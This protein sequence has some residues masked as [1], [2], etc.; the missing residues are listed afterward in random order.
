MRLG[1]LG[2]AN[3]QRYENLE[4]ADVPFFFGMAFRMIEDIDLV[5]YSLARAT[6]KETIDAETLGHALDLIQSG[7][8]SV[9]P[10]EGAI[11][12]DEAPVQAFV[13]P[14]MVRDAARAPLAHDDQALGVLAK[15]VNFQLNNMLIVAARLAQ[16]DDLEKIQLRHYLP[17]CEELPYPLNRYC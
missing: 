2:Y 13:N 3:L 1:N 4:I 12:F 15:Y 14:G 8:P 7:G 9:A 17:Y 5:A 16:R 6:G 10:R 11:T